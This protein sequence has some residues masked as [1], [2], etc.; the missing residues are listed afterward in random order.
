MVAKPQ[1]PMQTRP[2]TVA[3]YDRLPDE[4]PRYEL[5]D[6][7]L[8]EMPAPNRFHQ[9]LSIRLALRLFQFVE[10][11]DLGEVFEAPFDV[12]LL[13]SAVVQP[14]ILFVSN[15][16]GWIVTDKRVVG[17]PDLVVEISSSSTADHDLDDKRELYRQTG[18]PEYWFIDTDARTMTVW[19]LNDDHYDELS[20]DEDGRSRSA[21]LSGFTVD[22]ERVF[23]DS[24]RPRRG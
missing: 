10:E 5:I 8:I 12:Q 11:H 6:G 21:V 22:M 17:A 20:V 16:R 23:A 13:E 18:V 2:M 14:D 9:Q 15:A 1:L 24:D 7:E 3:D 19:V 4:G